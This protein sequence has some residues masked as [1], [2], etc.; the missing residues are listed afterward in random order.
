L[1]YLDGDCAKAREGQH[2]DTS[3]YTEKIKLYEELAGK[4]DL[5]RTDSSS[6]REK[7]WSSVKNVI[8]SKII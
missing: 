4:A 6:D 1:L 2:D 5:I 7:V 8:D 3:Y